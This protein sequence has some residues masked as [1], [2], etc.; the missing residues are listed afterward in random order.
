MRS[1]FRP[2]SR[3]VLATLAPLT[4][5]TGALLLPPSLRAQADIQ[6][7]IR[8]SQERLE[9]IRGERT[10]LQGEM[11]QLAGQVHTI[12]EEIEKVGE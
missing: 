3:V 8:V 2:A 7:S 4:V 1:D 10:T 11:T 5:C 12:S 6:E 9:S